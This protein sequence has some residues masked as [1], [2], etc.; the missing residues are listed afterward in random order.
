MINEPATCPPIE[1][2]KDARLIALVICFTFGVFAIWGSYAQLDAG[3]IA[4]GEIIPSGKIRTVHHLEGGIVKSILIKEGDRIVAG[5]LLMQLEDVNARVQL[6]KFQAS[7]AQKM[8]EAKRERSAWKSKKK[9]LEKMRIAAHEEFTI[10]EKLYKDSFISSVRLLQ[11]KGRLSEIDALISETESEIS[12]V[13]LKILEHTTDLKDVAVLEDRVAQTKI[14][15][16]QSG[17]VSDLSFNTI[18][19]VIPAGRKILDIVPDDEALL[20][21]AKIAAN[22]IDAVFPGLEVRINLSAYKTRNHIPLRGCIVMI[23]NTTF[24]D[25]GSGGGRGQPY[26][27]ARIEISDRVDGVNLVPG[28]LAEVYIINGHRSAIRYLFDPFIDSIERAL[29]LK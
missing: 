16:P 13:Q 27:R 15:A 6:S 20:I 29:H 11:L 26:Y 14:R 10:N 19:G 17:T 18:G 3:S 28:M 21:E 23:S 1:I 9:N 22:D 5:Q 8:T 25:E 4:Q 24:R 2:R 7:A 12:R